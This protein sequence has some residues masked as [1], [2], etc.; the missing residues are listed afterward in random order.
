MSPPSL[1]GR[2]G[3]PSR[4]VSLEV[5]YHLDTSNAASPLPGSLVNML[6]SVREARGHQE[7][8]EPSSQ[9]PLELPTSWASIARTDEDIQVYELSRTTQGRSLSLQPQ[10]IV[11]D[12]A[13]P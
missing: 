13:S 10:V 5:E 9:D 2:S 3:G 8:G 6:C 12:A 7:G 4:R 1:E 11:P